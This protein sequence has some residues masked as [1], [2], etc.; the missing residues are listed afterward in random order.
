ML[1]CILGRFGSLQAQEISQEYR[2]KAAFLVNFAR[3]ITWPE[4]SFSAKQQEFT[5]CVAGVNPFSNVL[6][7]VESKQIN[8]RKIRVTYVDSLRKVPQ[9]HLLYVSR[10][11]EEDLAYLSTGI[12]LHPV[13]TVSDIPGFVKAGGSIEFILK[14]NRLSFIINHSALK[15]RGIQAGASMLDLAASVR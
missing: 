7:A 15:Q 2:L 8:G 14:E 10:S 9:C 6:S 12:A 11:E 13:V 5:I 4:Q 1:I 3:F